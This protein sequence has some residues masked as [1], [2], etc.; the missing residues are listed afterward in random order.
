MARSA[1]WSHG[2]AKWAAL[3]STPKRDINM[4]AED[5]AMGSS[6]NSAEYRTTRRLARDLQLAFQ[7]DLTNLSLSLQGTDPMLLTANNAAE[8]RNK[9]LT[10]AERAAKLV[11]YIQVKVE[12][13]P[14]CYHALVEVLTRNSRYYSSILEKLNKTFVE[15]GGRLRESNGCPRTS[16]KPVVE[17]RG[18]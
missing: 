4:A 5:S 13:D 3:G 1:V 11:Q 14:N 18:S 12:S 6:E 9:M 15:E 7:N 10:D 17:V 8:V 2:A 16:P